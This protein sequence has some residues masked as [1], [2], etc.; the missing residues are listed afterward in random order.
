M[1]HPTL[2]LQSSFSTGSL[3]LVG[4]SYSDSLWSTPSARVTRLKISLEHVGIPLRDFADTVQQAE[5]KAY[6]SLC[7]FHVNNTIQMYV[8]G[9]YYQI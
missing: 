9:I 7:S 1:S 8:N 4:F 2:A 6:M 3:S 5:Y